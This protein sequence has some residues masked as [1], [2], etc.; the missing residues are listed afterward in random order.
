MFES[1]LKPL[2]LFENL[3]KTCKNELSFQKLKKS[4]RI[5]LID[6]LD[7]EEK[8]MNTSN[9]EKEIYYRFYIK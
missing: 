1:Y 9:I 6:N 3:L 4:F 8:I 2:T 5:T 7:F